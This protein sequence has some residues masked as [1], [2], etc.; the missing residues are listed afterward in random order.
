MPP[1]DTSP[2]QDSTPPWWI[3]VAVPGP[4]PGVTASA[5]RL[6]DTIDLESLRDDL[7]GVV[8]QAS[9]PAH[10]SVSDKRIRVTLGPA[11]KISDPAARIQ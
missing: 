5:A 7:A 8:H 9:A 11:R 3:G 1:A 10:V 2:P 4:G 6:K